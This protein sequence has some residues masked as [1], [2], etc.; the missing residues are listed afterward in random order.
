MT[1]TDGRR[2]LRIK[3]S[4]LDVM[5]QPIESGGTGIGIPDQ[6]ARTREGDYWIELK[7]GRY[8]T[9]GIKV[10]FRP[11]QLNWLRRYA[12][13]RGKARLLLFVPHEE[14][15]DF[16]W[17]VFCGLRGIKEFYFM[18]ELTTLGEGYLTGRVE[19]DKVFQT[20]F[21]HG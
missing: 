4:A 11:G 7:I 14:G 6:F 21:G 19:G 12:N 5:L 1:E 2:W 9:N 18:N 16:A 17:W 15:K 10:E 13:L 8:V 20:L 3:L